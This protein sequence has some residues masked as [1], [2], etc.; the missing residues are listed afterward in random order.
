MCQASVARQ[1][2]RQLIRPEF[3]KDM[4]EILNLGARRQSET[5]FQPRGAH[6]ACQVSLVL[7]QACNVA[8]YGGWHAITCIHMI[9]HGMRNILGGLKYMKMQCVLF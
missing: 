2:A 3:H 7:L 9:A 1:H 5:I 6:G 8:E 4:S